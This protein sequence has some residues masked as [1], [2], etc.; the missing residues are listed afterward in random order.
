MTNN[1]SPQNLKN[2]VTTATHPQLSTPR[3]NPLR[4]IPKWNFISPP[5]KTLY[6][7]IC[8]DLFMNPVLTKCSHTFC[9]LCLEQLQ[10]SFSQQS[11]IRRRNSSSYHEGPPTLQID[12]STSEFYCPLCR[13]SIR[14]RDVV[15]N[16]IVAS[17]IS[18][19][20]VYCKFKGS[21][22]HDILSVST[23]S[24]HIRLCMYRPIDCPHAKI[25]CPFKDK[26]F[27]VNG[28][29]LKSCP[30]ELFQVYIQSTQ[31]K[32]EQLHRNIQTCQNEI[33]TLKDF[34]SG[35]AREKTSITLK[36]SQTHSN[37]TNA[38]SKLNE[39]PLTGEMRN[40][41]RSTTLSD[42]QTSPPSTRKVSLT[43]NSNNQSMWKVQN[44]QCVRTLIGHRRGVTSLCIHPTKPLLISGSH[45][46]SIKLW[47][48]GDKNNYTNVSELKGH[49]YTVWSICS[50]DNNIYSAS[51]DGTIRIWDIPRLAEVH[52]LKACDR[53]VYSVALKDGL[54]FTGTYDTVSIYD[55]RTSQP[56]HI[57]RGHQKNIWQLK[58]YD[59]QMYSC[60]SDG[61]VRIWELHNY[62][63]LK[64]IEFPGS[65]IFSVTQHQ[66][67]IYAGTDDYSIKVY[68]KILDRL[69][70][71]ILAHTWEIW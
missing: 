32:I 20:Q 13:T 56:I 57:L 70:R 23:F 64:T 46:A 62:S 9:R 18:E 48:I 71:T 4:L 67:H 16:R 43:N 14:L 7:P 19:I 34:S 25:G 15:Y 55:Q 69:E 36:Q 2:D 6:C 30:Y 66:D 17:L 1:G 35:R 5:S 42:Y 51:A 40:R 31:Q 58:I 44:L 39:R 3:D 29:H 65:H 60:S 61:T 68:N 24:G 59:D 8:Q 47:K 54:V 28:I 53:K 21:G 10:I 49:E 50:K 11:N 52:T 38:S 37:N 41:Q 45:D 26:A 33:A 63:L 12:T 22:C 27:I